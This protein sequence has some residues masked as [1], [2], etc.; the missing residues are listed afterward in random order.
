LQLC[1]GL[2]L[3]GRPR[4]LLLYQGMVVFGRLFT[5]RL[6]GAACPGCGLV[7]VAARSAVSAKTVT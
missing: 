3:R 7:E 6:F 1:E 5:Q 4:Q 2:Q